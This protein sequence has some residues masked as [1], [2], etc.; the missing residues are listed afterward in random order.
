MIAT[1]SRNLHFNRSIPTVATPSTRQLHSHKSKPIRSKITKPKP[2]T[3]TTPK[4]TTSTSTS[5]RTGKFSKPKRIPSIK[6]NQRDDGFFTAKFKSHHDDDPSK[7]IRISKE[8][9]IEQEQDLD[10]EIDTQI[11]LQIGN[12]NGNGNGEIKPFPRPKLKV[13]SF[14][15]KKLDDESSVRFNAS[16]VSDFENPFLNTALRKE[17]LLEEKRRKSVSLLYA[18]YASSDS[19]SSY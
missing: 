10:D 12:E 16:T 11:D 19:L 9:E 18:T 5:G 6:P 8:I 15:K 13:N 2:T 1:I 7:G 14:L 17:S 3:T 4:T